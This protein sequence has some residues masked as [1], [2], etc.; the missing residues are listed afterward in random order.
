[1]NEIAVTLFDYLTSDFAGTGQFT[2]ICVQLLEEQGK[3][4]DG[5]SVLQTLVD[6]TDF[7][8]DKVIEI[9]I[10][11]QILIGCV[12]Q[13]LLF[14]PASGNVA[15]QADNSSDVIP[16]PSDNHGFLYVG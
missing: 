1:M 10:G 3:S 2:V 14:G 13:L 4:S 6:G 11:G 12:G 7:L 9:R 8:T 16:F 15:V 5:C